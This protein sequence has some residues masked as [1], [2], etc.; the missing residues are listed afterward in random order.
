VLTV[1]GA[2]AAAMVAS[3]VVVT[4]PNVSATRCDNPRAC[5]NGGDP[6]GPRTINNLDTHIQKGGEHGNKA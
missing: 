3:T 1:I 2:I 5:G 4:I 6:A